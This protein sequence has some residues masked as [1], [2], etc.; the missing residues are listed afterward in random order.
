M[1]AELSLSTT[2]VGDQ[3]FA[4]GFLRDISAQEQ[5]E[6]ALR[7][8]LQAASAAARAKSEFLAAMSHEIRTPLN[9]IMGMLDLVLDEPD[10]SSRKDRL[11]VARKSAQTLLHLLN[12]ILDYSR[13]DAGRI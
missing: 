4:V 1:P 3:V 11:V 10:G 2:R 13:L 8:A 9:G 5:Q 6:R 7:D 12:S